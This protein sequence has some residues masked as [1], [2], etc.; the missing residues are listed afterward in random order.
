MDAVW[1]AFVVGLGVGVGL[2]ML[3][4]ALSKAYT[5]P[6]NYSISDEQ[7]DNHPPEP[8]KRKNRTMWD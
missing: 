2:S 8:V 5:N 6:T 3:Y 7:M 4:V 1:V